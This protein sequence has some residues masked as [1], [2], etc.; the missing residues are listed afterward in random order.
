MSLTITAVIAGILAVALI[1]IGISTLTKSQQQQA[2]IHAEIIKQTN[3]ACRIEA[4]QGVPYHDT[5]KD[6]YP[7]HCDSCLGGKNNADQDKDGIPDECD[8][9]PGQR[10]ETAQGTSKK[11]ITKADAKTSCQKKGALWDKNLNACVLQ[12]YN[13]AE[14]YFHDPTI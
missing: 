1:V 4:L 7:D 12:S 8:D 14:P 9:E 11:I 5:D 6:G 2:P 3:E 13:T 10:V